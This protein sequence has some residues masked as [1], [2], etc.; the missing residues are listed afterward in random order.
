VARDSAAR[1][2]PSGPVGSDE[3]PPLLGSW[4]TLY[5]VLVVELVVLVA[6]FWLLT[7]WAA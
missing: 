4:R 7:R 5:A 1:G 3:P 2:G 6:G